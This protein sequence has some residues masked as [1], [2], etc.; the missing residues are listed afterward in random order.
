MVTCGCNPS[1]RLAGRSRSLELT[2]QLAWSNQ[3]LQVPVKETA[4]KLVKAPEEAPLR[5]IF[6]LHLDG[7]HIYRHVHPHTHKHKHRCTIKH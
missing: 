2:G 7:R 4:P 3:E 6:G 1:T 5:L